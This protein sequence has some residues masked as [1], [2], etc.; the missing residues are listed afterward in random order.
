[1]R[2]MVY[3]IPGLLRAQFQEAVVTS[4]REQ[5]RFGLQTQIPDIWELPP[6]LLMKLTNL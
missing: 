1:M 2:T 4:R 5:P 6:R 3:H